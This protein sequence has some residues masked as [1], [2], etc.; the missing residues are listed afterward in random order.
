MNALDQ[1]A[2]LFASQF[3]LL[4]A[5]IEIVNGAIGQM[6]E[7]TKNVKQWAV[8]VWAASIGGALSNERLTPFVVGTA[9]IPLLFW[10]VDTWHRRIQRKFIWRNIQIAGFINGGGLK[11]S[12]S[13]GEIVGFSLMD[14]KAR[15]AE[16]ERD[17]KKF[18]SWWRVALFASVCIL[19]LGMF[20]LSLAVAVIV[21]Y[22]FR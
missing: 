7:I 22:R 16:K 5:E 20:L 8:T 21:A 18:I 19:Y 1:H 12:L 17:F 2:P 13:R 11:Q 14:P 10:L 3:E 9:A 6:D 15:A 4:K